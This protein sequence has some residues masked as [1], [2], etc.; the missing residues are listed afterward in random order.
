MDLKSNM[1]FTGKREPHVAQYKAGV[2][3]AGL[4]QY[5]D[6]TKITI[7][8][9]LMNALVYDNIDQGIH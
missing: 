8:F 7:N 2:D 1:A 5:V 4:L 3:S 9:S 6:I